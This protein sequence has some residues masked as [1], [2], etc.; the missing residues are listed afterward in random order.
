MRRI[1]KWGLFGLFIILGMEI[2]TIAPKKIGTQEESQKSVQIKNPPPS[3]VATMSQVMHG[4]HLVETSSGQKEW[5]LD[6]ANA[7]GF[8]DKGTWKLQGV[9]VKFFGQGNSTYSVIGDHG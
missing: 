2:L 5:A 4:V 3:S 8:K 1:K 6:A 9:H 7:Q